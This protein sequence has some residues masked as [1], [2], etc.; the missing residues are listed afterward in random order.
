VLADLHARNPVADAAR[1]AARGDFRFLAVNG[2]TTM[3]PGLPKGEPLLRRL[4]YQ[5]LPETSD[6]ILDESCETYQDDAWAFAEAYNERMLAL[7][8]RPGL[9]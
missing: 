9:R 3:F 7:A 2:Y 4:G 8:K 6:L 5:V 1:N